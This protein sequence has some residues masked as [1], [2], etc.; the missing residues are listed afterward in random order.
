MDSLDGFL[1]DE[2]QLPL[3]WKIPS[4][5][6]AEMYKPQ[7]I[8]KCYMSGKTETLKIL[9]GPS[10]SLDVVNCLGRRL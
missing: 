6:E 8:N 9:Q 10:P 7:E 4:R 3:D 5:R 1:V 2:W